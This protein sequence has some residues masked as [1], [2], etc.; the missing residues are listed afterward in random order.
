MNAKFDDSDLHS[1]EQANLASAN[2]AENAAEPLPADVAARVDVVFE[3]GLRSPADLKALADHPLGAAV[4][5]LTLLELIQPPTGLVDRTLRAVAAELPKRSLKVGTKKHI[6]PTGFNQRAVDIWVMAV[7]ASVLAV[8]MFFS[9]TQ[10]QVHALRFACARNL[11]TVGQAMEQYAANYNNRLPEIAPPAD[12]NWLPRNV[13]TD[14]SRSA[15]A[16]SNLANLAPLVGGAARYTSWERLVCPATPGAINDLNSERCPQWG[17]TG[18]S[19]VDQLGPYHHHW[20]ESETVPIMADENPIVLDAYCQ[21]V[22]VNSPNHGGTGQNVLFNDG[23]AIWET[24]A[25]VGPDHH[26]IWT[27]G[28]PPVMQYNGTQEPRHRY[29]VFLV[30]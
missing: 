19:Y 20:V 29:S 25:D 28:N 8:V 3:N 7:A 21:N 1:G 30:P 4:A 27:L 22:A 17:A 6:V 2:G 10:A 16:H 15:D 14:V 26:S 13:N 9:I 5:R 24:S 18:Y 23:S 12:R 11:Q